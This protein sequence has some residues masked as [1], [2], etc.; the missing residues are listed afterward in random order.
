VTVEDLLGRLDGV[1][2]SGTGWSARCPAHE[3]RSPSLSIADGRDGAVLLK[4]FAGCTLPQICAAIAIEERDLFPE[5]SNA[6]P[7]SIVATYQYRAEN[8][9]LLF[10]VV[11]RH[12]KSFHQRKPDGRGGWIPSTLGV[13]QVLYRLPELLASPERRVFIVEG[14]KDVD[15]LAEAGFIATTNAGGAGKWKT[16]HSESLRGRHV[17]ILPDNDAPGE[18]HARTVAGALQGIAASVRI[19]ELPGLPPKGDI[20]DWFETGGTARELKRLAL[21]T[22]E[23]TQEQESASDH[24]AGARTVS[25]SDVQPE[26]VSWLWDGRIP[27]GKLTLL[28]GDP[29][30]GKSTLALEV[31]ARLTRG[32]RLPGGGLAEV[33]S[34]LILSAEDGLGDTIRPRL[35]AAGADVSRVFAIQAVS[36]SEGEEEFPCLR[37]VAEIE[38]A[39]RVRAARLLIVDPLMAYLGDKTNSWRDQDVRR[40][41]APVAAMAERTGA[42]VLIIRH[43][44]KGGGSNAVYRGGGSIGISGA[45][46]SVLLVAKDPEDEERRVLASAK[47]NLSRP[48]DSLAYRLRSAGNVARVEFEAAP[49]H[50]TADQLLAAQEG[51]EGRGALGEAE[52]FLRDLLVDRP[53]ASKDGLK[54]AREAGISEITLRRARERLGI[55]P[56]RI[57][58]DGAWFWGLPAEGDHPLPKLITPENDHLRGSHDQLRELDDEVAL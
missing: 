25:L 17:L 56:R 48:P 14:E 51:P 27:F 20:S 55:R 38:E 24:A 9:D 19:L 28:D 52:A 40:A 47:S 11:R 30:L 8:R 42:A 50:L 57:G 5:T 23:W 13:R 44:T 39:I 12:P 41:L 43:L 53:V 33:S 45:A 22:P 6:K 26:E 15:R 49:V 58:F 16:T 34:V 35:E 7:S 32:E 31:A 3:D 1:R 46:R 36:N 29:G 4:C 37:H 21:E 54:A 18:R 10:E 2:R